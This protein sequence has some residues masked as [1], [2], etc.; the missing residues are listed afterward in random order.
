MRG[1][2]PGTELRSAQPS[3]SDP[4]DLPRAVSE[5][6]ADLHALLDAADVPGPY[7][8]VADSMGGLLARLYAGTYPDEV[9][10]FVSVDAAHEIYYEAYQELLPPELYMAPGIEIDVVEAAAAMRR[11]RTEQPLRQMPMVVLEHSRD[12]ERFPNPFGLPPELPI[13]ALELAFQASQ[14]DLASLVPGTQHVIATNSEHY[15]HF[16]EPALV[17]DETR[18][19]VDAVRRGESRLGSDALADT[20]G[21]T[22]ILVSMAFLLTGIRSSACGSFR[23]HR[24][25]PTSKPRGDDMPGQHAFVLVD[26]IA[27]REGFGTQWPASLLSRFFLHDAPGGTVTSTQ[28]VHRR[29]LPVSASGSAAD[30]SQAPAESLHRRTGR[31][32]PMG[33][34]NTTTVLNVADHELG[35]AWYSDLF[36]R[37]PDRRPMEGSA[38]WQ[39][40]PT[41]AVMVYADA[42]TAGGGNLIVGVDDL[43]A[44]TAELYEREIVLEPYT[45]P[46][47]QFRLAEL[48]DPSGNTVT[49]AQ[50][51]TGA[52]G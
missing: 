45:V 7:V 17:V 49:F 12:R 52:P 34:T 2:R 9:A 50:T 33:V 15:I 11:A 1:H 47:G 40:T 20:G 48:A 21:T 46:S 27:E 13:E 8:L 32:T 38:E 10:G 26:H 39:V 16:S 5:I 44:T 14:D 18:A 3:R 31:R 41:S 51:L 4:V 43:D 22:W 24:A 37:E 30:E 35:V 36:G 28:T 23:P 42:D 6:V 19:V 29:T 25:A